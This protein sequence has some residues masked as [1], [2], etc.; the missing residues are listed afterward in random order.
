MKKPLIT[1]FI[2][3]V[4]YGLIEILW[5]G[6]THYSMLLAGGIILL[7][8]AFINE[9]NKDSP[10]L[11]RTLTVTLSVVAIELVF[12]LVFN[13]LLKERVWDYSAKSFNFKGQI[14]LEYTLLWLILSGVICTILDKITDTVNI[15]PLKGKQY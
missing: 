11:L 5:R 7:F 6:R 14:C 3:A 10:L 13:I 9:R 4:G 15:F 1:F 12:G 2:G 8:A